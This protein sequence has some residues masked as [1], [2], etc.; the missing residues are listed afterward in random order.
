MAGVE[1]MLVTFDTLASLGSDVSREDAARLLRDAASLCKDPACTKRLRA[2]ADAV[3]AGRPCALTQDGLTWQQAAAAN[4]ITR[5]EWQARGGDSALPADTDPIEDDD[6][7]EEVMEEVME[8]EPPALPHLPVRHFFPGLVVR[9]GREFSDTRGRAATAALVLRLLTA[10]Q[11]EDG[12]T[13]CF[14]DRTLRLD[15]S[16]PGYDDVV[17]NRKNRWFQPVPGKDCLEDLWELVDRRLTEADLDEDDPDTECLD[18]IVYEV[19]ECEAW[20]SSESNAPAPV[21]KSAPLA[22]KLFGRD[23]EMA[24]W[25]RLLFAGVVAKL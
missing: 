20:L 12:Y 8:E 7:D 4:T 14:Y 1:S 17:E 15:S 13:L 16:L 21:C 3:A 18:E 2:A 19:G 5:E 9:L 24:A 25:V 10:E 6:A 22:G 11:H 23:S